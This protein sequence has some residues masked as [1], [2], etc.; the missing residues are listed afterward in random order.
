MVDSTEFAGEGL[1]QVPLP[2]HDEARYLLSLKLCA[3][4]VFWCMI[5]PRLGL[6]ALAKD[7][8]P[9]KYE[10]EE[11]QGSTGSTKKSSPTKTAKSSQKQAKPSPKTSPLS[12]Y[13]SLMLLVL[14]GTVVSLCYLL[15]VDSPNNALLARGVFEAP[16]FTEAECQELLARALAVAQR[17]TETAITVINH[18]TTQNENQDKNTTMSSDVAHQLLQ[19]PQ[20]WQKARHASY[21]TTDLNLVTDPF[22]HDDRHWMAERFNRRLAPLLARIYGISLLSIRAND[23]FLVR[24]DEGIRDR[25]DAHTDNGDV[26]FNIL[27]NGDFEGGGTRFWKRHGRRTSR[28]HPPSDDSKDDTTTSDWEPF[29][30]AQPAVGHV[31]VNSATIR[32]EGLPITQGTRYILVGFLSVDRVNPFTKQSTHLSWFASWLSVPWLSV[33]MLT[34]ER[35]ATLQQSDPANIV[36]PRGGGEEQERAEEETTTTRMARTWNPLGSWSTSYLYRSA[37]KSLNLLA[38]VMAIH[39]Y[40]RLVDPQ[41]SDLY[42]RVMDH[43]WTQKQQSHDNNN[44]NSQWAMETRT[45]I[46][47]SQTC[48]RTSSMDAIPR[49]SWFAGQHLTLDVDGSIYAEWNIRRQYSGSYPLF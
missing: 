27:L 38:D 43:Q 16:M 36:D 29:A 18:D 32:H 7:R 15:M 20:G 22:T 1:L 4:L 39:H 34:G 23:L 33:R 47:A 21:A 26:S 44:N 6:S 40:T 8:H 10:E 13:F 12:S 28:H 42:L 2:Q 48:N 37:H 41:H 14:V 3:A 25:L 19:A 49:A 9:R 17:N 35:V 45:G 11:K 5:V 30:V 31:L 24:Y 46:N